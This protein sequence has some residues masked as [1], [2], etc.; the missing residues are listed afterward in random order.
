MADEI[1]EQQRAQMQALA[2]RLTGKPDK[3]T[4]ILLLNGWLGGGE[5]APCALLWLTVVRAEGFDIRLAHI[6]AED[7]VNTRLGVIASS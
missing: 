2:T 3:M 6:F 1:T 5:A 4:A 7:A